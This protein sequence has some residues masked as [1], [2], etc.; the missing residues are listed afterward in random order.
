MFADAVKF[1]KNNPCIGECLRADPN[2]DDRY[3]PPGLLNRG[4]VFVD[5]MSLMAIWPRELD[6]YRIMVCKLDW[7][8]DLEYYNLYEPT[9]GPKDANG[10][11]SGKDVVMTNKVICL[12]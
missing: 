5:A 9:N 1:D 12:F 10:N 6:E 8:S 4:G 2:P 3:A 11:W 7:R